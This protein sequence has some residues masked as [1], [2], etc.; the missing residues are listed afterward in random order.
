[1]SPD[2]LIL[3]AIGWIFGAFV[4]GGPVAWS[5]IRFGLKGFGTDGIPWN[6]T[7]SLTGVCG[8]TVG[9]IVITAG[10]LVGAE[11]ILKVVG[12]VYWIGVWDKQIE[13]A[14]QLREANKT[15][16]AQYRE[17]VLERRAEELRQQFLGR[18]MPVATPQE[19]EAN[20]VD[21]YEREFGIALNEFRPES[22]ALEE[23]VLYVSAEL[24][25]AEQLTAKGLCEL[26]ESHFQKGYDQL[27]RL[28][29]QSPEDVQ[30]KRR[31]ANYC[32]SFSDSV[33]SEEVCED[34]I[35]QLRDLLELDSNLE[36]RS[37]LG[38]MLN[39]QG[40][41][42]IAAERLDEAKVLLEE[43]IDH[44]KLAFIGAPEIC[45][46]RQFLDNHFSN[47]V[48]CLTRLG[49]PAEAVDILRARRELWPDN[50]LLL[51]RIAE[52]YHSLFDIEEDPAAREVIIE[53][54]LVTLKE[55]FGN[56]YT[57]GEESSLLE[58]FSVLSKDERFSAVLTTL[59]KES[60]LQ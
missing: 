46:S 22:A 14:R 3:K 20:I 49:M 56:G 7:K 37:A 23:L 54:T 8:K 44:Q 10:L 11:S 33:D 31:F 2:T 47:L 30:L 1:M 4:I 19:I 6:A 28:V 42:F 13:E 5:L 38:A 27:K 21:E 15:A 50:G 39:N 53:E 57:V 48:C 24:E 32:W 34:G 36:D 12:A 58:S 9:G 45:R 59:I 35:R 60:S 55:A 26:A 51:F 41:R 43:A 40:R 25:V 29:E 17:N 16:A 18:L 52:Q